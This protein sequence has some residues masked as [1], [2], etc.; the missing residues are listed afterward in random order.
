MIKPSIKSNLF[1]GRRIHLVL[2]SWQ[3]DIKVD[4]SKYP[5]EPI[6]P[7]KVERASG[8]FSAWSFPFSGQNSGRVPLSTEDQRLKAR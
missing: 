2:A 8:Y 6:L 7:E 1:R 5:D 4:L 3:E